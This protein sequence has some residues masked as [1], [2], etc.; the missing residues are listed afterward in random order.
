MRYPLNHQ[1][2]ADS[3]LGNSR[4][5][6]EGQYDANEDH[7]LHE[8][9]MEPAETSSAHTS[10]VSEV[11]ELDAMVSVTQNTRPDVLAINVAPNNDD[12]TL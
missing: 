12:T 9:M 3:L 7:D 1:P 2:E 5:I 6:E 4:W 10:E 11:N 8:K